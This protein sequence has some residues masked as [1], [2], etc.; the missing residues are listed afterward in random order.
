[1]KNFLAPLLFGSLLLASCQPNPPIVEPAPEPVPAAVT[2]VSGTVHLGTQTDGTATNGHV[3][4]DAAGKSMRVWVSTNAGNGTGVNTTVGS[5]LKYTVTLPTPL[6]SEVTP[7]SL[8][9]YD[10]CT[11]TAKTVTAGL[12]GT[13]INFSLNAHP[14]TNTMHYLEPVR[15]E[16]T[17]TSTTATVK[18][19]MYVNMD[20]V[21]QVKGVCTSPDG[22]RTTNADTDLKL[23]KGWNIYSTVSKVVRSEDGKVTSTFTTRNDTGAVDLYAAMQYH[24]AE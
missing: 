23:K 12:R 24:L 9:N 10:T 1:M 17:D 11:M 5:D 18:G 21:I 14:E 20:G 8:S 3:D 15:L 6:D 7:F 4:A 19:V 13:D 16:L 22:L 2:S